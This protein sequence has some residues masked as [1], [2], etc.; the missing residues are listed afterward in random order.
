MGVNKWNI[1]YIFL[2]VTIGLTVTLSSCTQN[3]IKRT[4]AEEDRNVTRNAGKNL[5][6]LQSFSGDYPVAGLHRLPS[7]QDRQRNGYFSSVQEFAPVWQMMFPTRTM[8]EIDFTKNIVVFSRNIQFFNRTS[9]GR[10]V[11][12]GG[13]VEVMAMETLSSRPIEDKVAMALAVIPLEGVQYINTGT[14]LITVTR[15]PSSDPLNASYLIDGHMVKLIHGHAEEIASPGSATKVTTHV[16]EKT[17][18]GDV[19]KDGNDDAVLILV[20]DS[21]GSGTYYYV[22]ASLNVKGAY[23]GTNA[24]FLGDRI[25]PGNVKIEKGLIVVEYSDRTAKDAM[26]TP[27]A[28]SMIKYLKVDRGI[29][30]EFNPLDKWD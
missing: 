3:T 26:I 16:A 15:E 18:Y 9:I 29:L 13:V 27:P 10:V 22:A 23:R 28:E 25:V 20:R 24:V 6:I 17:A 8:P 11:L 30:E 2:A 12:Q 5:L 19:D 7:G 4:F 14:T 21:G 1:I